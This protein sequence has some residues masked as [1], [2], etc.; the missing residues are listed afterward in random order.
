MMVLIHRLAPA[1]PSVVAAQ[2]M[3]VFGIELIKLP[4]TELSKVNKINQFLK[5]I[6]N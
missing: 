1:C 2:M 5:F 4:P 3:S 6:T